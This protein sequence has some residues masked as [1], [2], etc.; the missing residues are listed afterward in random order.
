MTHK[1]NAQLIMLPVISMILLV[2]CQNASYTIV[3]TLKT[4]YGDLKIIY[5]DGIA[6]LNG[7]LPRSTPCVYYTT[8]ISGSKDSP[9]SRI[10]IGIFK[11]T[12]GE[13]CIQVLGE[14][15]QIYEKI[16]GVSDKTEYVLLER[17]VN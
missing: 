13:V 17:G 1:K 10:D 5:N 7:S 4:P 12:K 9:I 15:Q 2:S 8:E 14:P 16:E 3:K 11:K 6:V